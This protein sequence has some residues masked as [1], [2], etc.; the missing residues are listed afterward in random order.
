MSDAEPVAVSTAGPDERDAR[1]RPV[2]A[3]RH[4]AGGKR[5]A[6]LAD[7]SEATPP[8]A[9]PADPG[10]LAEWTAEPASDRPR[11]TRRR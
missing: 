6:V 3:W 9:T 7:G 4:Y 10:S 8:V 11:R 1:G 2:V 5:V